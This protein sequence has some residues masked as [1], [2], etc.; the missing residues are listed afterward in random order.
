VVLSFSKLTRH[1][2]QGFAKA[3]VLTATPAVVAISVAALAI[4]SL[5]VI[6]RT[7][8]PFVA[9]IY[10]RSSYRNS[11]P[12]LVGPIPHRTCEVTAWVLLTRVQEP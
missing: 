2:Y 12:K 9:A 1:V 7:P 10:S 11:I 6:F 8:I 5:A 3:G 4:A